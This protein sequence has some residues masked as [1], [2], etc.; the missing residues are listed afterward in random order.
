VEPFKRITT[1]LDFAGTGRQV[2]CLRIV[3]PMNESAWHTVE[4]PAAVIGNGRGPTILLTGGVHGDEFEGQV[5]L[6]KLIRGLSPDRVSG[7]LIVLPAL[8]HPAAEAGQ[9][10][11]PIDGRDLNRAF[12]GAPDGTITAALADY[13][14]TV[15]LPQADA[16]LDIHSGGRSMLFLNCLWMNFVADRDLMA[17]S[18]AA[19]RAFGAPI[20]L[21]TAPLGC[22]AMSDSA[23]RLGKMYL[24]TEVGGGAAVSPAAMRVVEEG[25]ERLLAHFGLLPPAEPAPAGRFM[26][27]PDNAFYLSAPS[28]GLLEPL[29]EIGQEIAAGQAFGR[30][31]AVDRPLA[32]PIA[33][34]ARQGGTLVGRRALGP[35][36]QGD[37]VAVIAVD[38]DIA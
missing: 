27:V 13:V 12:P 11:S 14:E 22:G 34:E 20:T 8:N 28:P 2:S 38:L 4:I 37:G 23:E 3:Q 5:A 24:S 35:V 32:A 18:L 7:R 16:I 33:I 36:R 15:L 21:V 26:Q 31:H 9:R 10:L 6:L 1:D 17:R 19:A 29:F 25:L 30:I